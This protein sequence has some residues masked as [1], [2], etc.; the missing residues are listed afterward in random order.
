MVFLFSMLLVKLGIFCLF[1][2]F[3]C[4]SIHGAFQ[5]MNNIY[6]KF[7]FPVKIFSQTKIL[8]KCNKD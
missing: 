4:E 8:V 5:C 3:V 1:L 7:I 6:S 2:Y